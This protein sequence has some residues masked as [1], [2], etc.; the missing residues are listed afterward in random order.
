MSLDDTKVFQLIGILLSGFGIF[1]MIVYAIMSW[2][3]EGDWIL[4]DTLWRV[5]IMGVIIF[6]FGLVSVG[7]GAILSKL[8]TLSS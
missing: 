5:M 4:T 7:I 1:V 8:K 6:N 3:L 2:K